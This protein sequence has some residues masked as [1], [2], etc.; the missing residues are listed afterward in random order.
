MENEDLRNQLGIGLTRS[1]GMPST[2]YNSINYPDMSRN[3]GRTE[4]PTLATQ[5][6]YG[7][8]MSNEYRGNEYRGNEYRGNEYR[9]HNQDYNSYN[10]G[11]NQRGLMG[12][13]D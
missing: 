5:K 4:Y 1:K 10:T 7:P 9:D 2:Q 6:N 13:L 12:E 11:M 3:N 8:Q